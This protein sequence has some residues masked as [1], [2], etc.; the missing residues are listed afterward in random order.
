MYVKDRY[1][2]NNIEIYHDY[3]GISKWAF[4]LWKTNKEATRK[5]RDFI[6]SIM[7]SYSISF[8]HVKGHSGNKYNELADKYAKEGINLSMGT[9]NSSFKILINQ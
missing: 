8:K 5:Y 6:K 2:F 1:N 9:G 7:K 3:I 4:G